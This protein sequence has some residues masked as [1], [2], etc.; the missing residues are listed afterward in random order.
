MSKKKHTASFLQLLLTVHIP[1]QVNS[2][3]AMFLNLFQETLSGP[4][5]TGTGCTLFDQLLKIFLR[6]LAL[7]EKIA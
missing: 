1:S 4:V 6:N 7:K 3:A 2:L 5:M